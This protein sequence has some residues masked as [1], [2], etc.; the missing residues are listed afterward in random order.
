[1]GMG[2]SD[3]GFREAAPLFLKFGAIRHGTQ[4]LIRRM[5]SSLSTRW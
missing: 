3:A 1:M 2:R 4:G 5:V